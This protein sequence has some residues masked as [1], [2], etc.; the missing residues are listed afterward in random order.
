MAAGLVY[1][2]AAPRYIR[3]FAPHELERAI[4]AGVWLAPSPF[5]GQVPELFET[6]VYLRKKPNFPSTRAFPSSHFAFAFTLGLKLFP[7]FVVKS[8]DY[9][10]SSCSVGGLFL[11]WQVSLFNRLLIRLV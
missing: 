7:L 10:S 1:P 2:P 11:M 3:F 8:Q 5:Q 6:H 4:G 9:F